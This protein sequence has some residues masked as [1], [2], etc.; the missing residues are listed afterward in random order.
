MLGR[1]GM[2]YVFICAKNA[3]YTYVLYIKVGEGGW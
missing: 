1:L 3:I 2:V